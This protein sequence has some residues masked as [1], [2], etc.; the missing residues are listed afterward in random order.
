MH[1]TTKQDTSREI[2]IDKELGLEVPGE[3]MGTVT[4]I[5]KKSNNVYIKLL[6]NMNN[7]KDK[8]FEQYWRFKKHQI[9]EDVA[10]NDKLTLIIKKTDGKPFIVVSKYKP[11]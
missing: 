2:T 7:P 9:Q 5:D 11:N 8:S 10:V 1:K 6:Y 3:Y 4:K